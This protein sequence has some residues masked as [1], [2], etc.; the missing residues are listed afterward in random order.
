[1]IGV[2]DR[3]V[4][5]FANSCVS[6]SRPLFDALAH[7]DMPHDIS[8]QIL[9]A[10]ASSRLQYLAATHPLPLIRPAIQEFDR[11]LIATLIAKF[12]LPT[13]LPKKALEQICL[14][15][16]EGGL[17]VRL[18]EASSNALYASAVAQSLRFTGRLPT[19]GQRDRALQR[20][21][22]DLREAGVVRSADHRS[23]YDRIPSRGKS[24]LVRSYMAQIEQQRAQQFARTLTPEDFSRLR[25]C[26]SKEAC[27]HFQL[28]DRAEYRLDAM[29]WVSFIHHRLDLDQC[30][31]LPA[32][33]SCGRPRNP[34]HFDE[35]KWH[36]HGTITDRHDGIL[37]QS[38][39][40]FSQVFCKVKQQPRI[41]LDGGR[42][43]IAAEKQH[44]RPD[45]LYIT[46][47]GSWY[48]DVSVVD[49]ASSS[50]SAA[51]A[52]D[53]AAAATQRE[54]AKIAHY[55]D[56]CDRE[57][58]HFSP[59]VLESYGTMGPATLKFIRLYARLAERALVGATAA[60]ARRH[61]TRLLEVQLVRGNARASRRYISRAQREDIAGDGEHG[62]DASFDW[63][64]AG[65]SNVSRPQAD[66]A[67]WMRAATRSERKEQAHR[68]AVEMGYEEQVW[69]PE[70]KGA[71][72]QWLVDWSPVDWSVLDLVNRLAVP[73]GG[74]PGAAAARAVDASVA[75]AAM[76][77]GAAV[78]SAAVPVGGSL[79]PPA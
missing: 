51:G 37:H 70:E 25:S 5:S 27:V 71:E 47:S 2:N 62:G 13:P 59:I 55:K 21:C 58:A 45:A 34:H 38:N 8:L 67:R 11:Q 4:S 39:T 74:G 48:V 41:L 68:R 3:A 36:T 19:E 66:R 78:D 10:C 20:C 50:Y 44:V 35:C 72:G 65:F 75:A 22:S 54:V 49:P 64:D 32:N 69:D 18:V 52:R 7:D 6:D 73:E 77:G 56:L 24:L 31:W 29:T 42:R 1:M 12:T 23:F 16:K 17:G 76:A 61:F 14:P 79:V 30:A 53:R 60:A 15:L 9:R 26:G 46:T 33:C 63:R 43:D 57:G 28:A 40:L